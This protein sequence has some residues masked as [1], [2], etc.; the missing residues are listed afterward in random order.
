[1]PVLYAY[2]DRWAEARRARRERLEARRAGRAAAAHG[3]SAAD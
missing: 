2:L 3:S 1:V